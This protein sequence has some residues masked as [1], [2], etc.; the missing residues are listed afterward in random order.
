MYFCSHARHN[1]TC[2]FAFLI[3]QH[4][5]ETRR[6]LSWLVVAR[7]SSAL[8]KFACITVVSIVL[9]IVANLFG[10]D[11]ISC[12]VNK[13]FLQFTDLVAI[14]VSSR[15]ERRVFIRLWTVKCELY[16]CY[17]VFLCHLSRRFDCLL[18]VFFVS[19]F[20]GFFAPSN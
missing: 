20:V 19:L 5:R 2:S 8:G 18:S 16:Y 9:A 10:W 7:V 11:T 4:F 15:L 14:R 6:C 17:G 13:I 3:E 1:T 12:R